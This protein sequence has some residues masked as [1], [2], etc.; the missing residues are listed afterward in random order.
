M[1]GICIGL[2]M[3]VVCGPLLL[4]GLLL[5]WK[6]IP[7]L[8]WGV[9]TDATVVDQETDKEGDTYPVIEFVDQSGVTHRVTLGVG[10][11]E[12]VGSTMSVMYHARN[13]MDVTGT[14]VIQSW[15]PLLLFLV[16]GG[17]GVW[18]GVRVLSG[19]F[20]LN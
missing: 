8:L 18:I 2:F 14:S 6:T 20:P 4:I 5:A 7:L 1:K 16:L 10:G 15:L 19:N 11:G 12:P 9:R 13:P 17:G 3:I